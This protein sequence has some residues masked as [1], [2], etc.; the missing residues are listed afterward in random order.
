MYG[1]FTQVNSYKHT[2]RSGLP[3]NYSSSTF[4]NPAI[5]G[6]W[7]SPVYGTGLKTE[8]SGPQGKGSFKGGVTEEARRHVPTLAKDQTTRRASSVDRSAWTGF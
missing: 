4:D 7:H 3:S 2:I 8:P 5:T 6:L 1:I